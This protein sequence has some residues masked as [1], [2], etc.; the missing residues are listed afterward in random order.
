MTGRKELAQLALTFLHRCDLKGIEARRMV[1]VQAW[2]ETIAR[3]TADNET[4]ADPRAVETD[5]G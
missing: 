1:E 4:V 2:L 5:N 3:G